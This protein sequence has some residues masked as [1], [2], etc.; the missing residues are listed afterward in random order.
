MCTTKKCADLKR[1]LTRIHKDYK[2]IFLSKLEKRVV[3]TPESQVED[4]A[5]QG[6]GIVQQQTQVSTKGKTSKPT[7]TKEE[8]SLLI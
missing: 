2:E 7:K 8:G 5:Q 6:R 1:I 3:S 4:V